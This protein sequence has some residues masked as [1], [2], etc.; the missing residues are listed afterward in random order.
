MQKVTIKAEKLGKSKLQYLRLL[1]NFIHFKG[2]VPLSNI[3]FTIGTYLGINILTF[4]FNY[5]N[6]FFSQTRTNLTCLWVSFS[7][8]S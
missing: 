2:K 4:R 6:L 3:I 5:I 8:K 1:F 7:S